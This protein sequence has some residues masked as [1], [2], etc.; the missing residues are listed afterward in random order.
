MNKAQARRLALWVNGLYLLGADH[1]GFADGELDDA[2]QEK[3]MAS[4]DAIARD[5]IARSGVPAHVDT[6]EAIR[7][8]LAGERA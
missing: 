4:K 6:A 1:S 2:Q 5:M 7:M 8:V 3:V